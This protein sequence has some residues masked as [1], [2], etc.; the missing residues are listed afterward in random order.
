M[1]PKGV[2]NF[3]S[4]ITGGSNI[5][6]PSILIEATKTISSNTK[7]ANIMN[8]F[9][10]EKVKKI[11]KGFKPVT[12]DPLI[13]LKNL[14]VKPKS[15]FT[16]PYIS[17]DEVEEIIRKS[18][19]SSAR[20]FDQNIMKFLK[21]TARAWAAPIA[22]VINKS[23]VAGYFPEI[24]KMSR[25]LPILKSGKDKFSKESYRPIS[26]LHC[27]EKIFEQHIKTHFDKYC[28]EN[29]IILKNHHGG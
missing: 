23:L 29:N 21:T 15:K 6:I 3:I 22:F 28:E 5:S 1:N 17:V 27:I 25:I 26:N 24:L 10:Y 19:N 12:Y 16:I 13:F 20:G 11:I 2:W 8:N 9:F 4:T 14:I 7:I 18:K